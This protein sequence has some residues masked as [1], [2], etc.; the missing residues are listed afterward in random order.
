MTAS[1]SNASDPPAALSERLLE[2]LLNELRTDRERLR[3]EHRELVKERRSERRWK[4]LFQLLLFG[5]PLLLGMVYLLFFTSAMG[6]QWGPFGNVVGVIRI[7]GAITPGGPASAKRIVPAIEKAFTHPNVRAIVISI[8]SPGGAAAEAER[9]FRAIE[10]LR[11]KHDKPVVAVINNIGASAA[12]MIAMHTD[13][14]YA[15]RYS[16]VGSIGAML[17]GWDVHKALEHLDITQRVYA[18]GRFKSM[19]S[20]FLPMSPEADDK[21]R[22]LVN[23]GGAAFL[24]DLRATRGP[25]LRPNIAYDSGEVWVG[26]EAKSIGLIDEIATLDDVI[27]NTWGIKP[28]EF[29]P[30]AEGFG[31]WSSTFQ[32]FAQALAD[33]L[34]ARLSPALY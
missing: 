21:A 1:R 16:L 32:G 19:L 31:P 13:R 3:V 15:T 22:Q 6:F 8:D 28:Y 11:K 18:S 34:V 12:Y 27:A 4:I 20:P 26:E 25:L 14:I 17:D 30:S 7:D 5:G 24:A 10:S 33:A 9:I 23:Q 2:E 29:G